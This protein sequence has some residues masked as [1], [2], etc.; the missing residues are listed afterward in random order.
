MSYQ[1]PLRLP[2][3]SPLC[4]PHR[5]IQKSGKVNAT[6]WRYGHEGFVQATLVKYMITITWTNDSIH[7]KNLKILHY[8][9][10]NGSL[11][12]A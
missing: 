2:P 7:L 11:K 9:Q 6:A 3:H 1:L 10:Q 8:K 12:F 4:D 5:K